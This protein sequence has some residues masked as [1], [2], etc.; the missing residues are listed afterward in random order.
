MHHIQGDRSQTLL[1]PNSVADYI[2]PDNPVRFV[3][4]FVDQLD[5]GQSKTAT[6]AGGRFDGA[7]GAERFSGSRSCAS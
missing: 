5:L 1:L 4:A 7:G 3:E 2:G 6:F